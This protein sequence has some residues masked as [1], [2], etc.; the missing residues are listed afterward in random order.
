MLSAYT[1]RS[2]GKLFYELKFMLGLVDLVDVRD[3]EIMVNGCNMFDAYLSVYNNADR[4]TFRLLNAAAQKRGAIFPGCERIF[5]N[6]VYPFLYEH[7][8]SFSGKPLDFSLDEIEEAARQVGTAL[9]G[10]DHYDTVRGWLSDDDSRRLFDIEVMQHGLRAA[11]WI[12][13]LTAKA[14][15]KG[16]TGPEIK[17]LAKEA[18]RTAFM[19]NFTGRRDIRGLLSNNRLINEERAQLFL[20]GQY[21]YKDLCAPRQGEV[22]FDCGA[23]Y[24]DTA[25]WAMDMVGDYGKVVSFEPLPCQAEAT[26]RNV[27][28]HQRQQLPCVFVEC[29]GVSDSAGE[30][31]F[32]DEEAGTFQSDDGQIK[33]K[34]VRI[35]DWCREHDLY[36]DF[37]KMDIE[38]GELSALRGGGAV[39][40]ERKPRLAISIYHKPG[41]D[42]WKIPNFLKVAVP[43]YRFYLKS[44]HPYFD[45]V[46]F[47]V[48]D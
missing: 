7:E 3:N 12:P 40:Q 4:S 39:I 11:G 10:E 17:K 43:E 24:G 1:R 32:I 34:T 18:K 15:C 35:D 28:R 44:A 5:R 26:K 9:L 47:A 27:R 23:C 20:L 2:L 13:E 22:F 21:Q 25:V 48:A 42:L 31:S 38:G 30:F 46:L 45:T 29:V 14:F 37:I 6:Y 16:L 36:P 19:K 8:A 33:C 41:E